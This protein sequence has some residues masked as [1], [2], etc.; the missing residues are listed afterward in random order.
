LIIL[1]LSLV[2]KTASIIKYTAADLPLKEYFT[3]EFSPPT[4]METVSLLQ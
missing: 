1:S 2:L 3:F 4:R